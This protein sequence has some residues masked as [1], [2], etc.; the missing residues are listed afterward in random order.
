MPPAH[1]KK[2]FPLNEIYKF[3]AQGLRKTPSAYIPFLIFAGID[4]ISLLLIYLAP[5][6][7]LIEFFGPPI[8]RLWGERFLHYPANFLLLPKLTADARMVLA[9]FIGSLLTGIC[10]TLLYQKPLKSAFKKYVSLFLI[11]FLST[12]LF[13]GAIKIRNF[14]LMKYFMAG[15]RSLLFLIPGAWLGPISTAMGFFIGLFIQAAFAYAI[16]ALIMEDGKLIRALATS[17]IFSAKHLGATIFLVGL[18]MLLY[19]PLLVLNYNSTFLMD[20][21]LPEIVFWL[22]A[23]SVVVNSLFIDPLITIATAELYRHAAHKP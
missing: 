20:R 9:V 10:V 14:A 23:T 8:R 18:P 3:A 15:H 2:T 7:P 1:P 19:V 16:P 6:E 17:I 4:F 13:Y 5:R 22:C 11:V 21:F 12:V